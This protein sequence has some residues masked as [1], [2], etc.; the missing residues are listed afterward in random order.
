MPKGGVRPTFTE[1]PVIRQDSE[2]ES[3]VVFECKLVGDPRPDVAWFHNETKC[4]KNKIF[5]R[6]CDL[7]K[8]LFSSSQA[9]IG[10]TAQDDN[11]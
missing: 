6:N 11:G 3:R 8:M 4:G 7:R 10:S 9:E 5:W 1:R 2:D